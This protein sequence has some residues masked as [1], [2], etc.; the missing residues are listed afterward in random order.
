[1]VS[2]RR[3]ESVSIP[4]QGRGSRILIV[5]LSSIGDVVHGLPLLCALRDSLPEAHLAWIVEDLAAVLLEGHSA[6]D[7]I[8]RLPHRWFEDSWYRPAQF[9]ATLTQLRRQFGSRGFDIAI[10]VQGLTKSA[11]TAWMSGAAHRIGF[12]GVDGRQQSRWI[13][14]VLV[15]PR[16]SLVVERNLE[17]L[18]PLGVAAGGVHSRLPDYPTE[19]ASVERFLKKTGLE[20]GRF[21]LVAPGSARAERLWPVERFAAVAT[22]IGERYDI[23][24]VVLWAGARERRWARQIADAS[25]GPVRVAPPTSLTELAVLARR[26]SLFIGSDTGPLHVAAAVGCTCV[27]LHGPTS[28]GRTGPYGA[29]HI[30]IQSGSA[31]SPAVPRPKNRPP[32]KTIS[33]EEVFEACETV[34]SR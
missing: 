25:G 10:D 9:L 27:S 14:N 16:S 5:R 28:A 29:Q 34:L 13:N 4:P 17:L 30:A 22:K 32:M 21:V 26:A 19:T 31:P 11:L 20:R 8:I 23:P 1:M 15:E 18:G 12:D 2:P 6:L 7:E 33:V 3:Q 24:T